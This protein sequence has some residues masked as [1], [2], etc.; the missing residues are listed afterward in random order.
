M[1]REDKIENVV[2]PVEMDAVIDSNLLRV[3]LGIEMN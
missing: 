2:W 1:F 3:I